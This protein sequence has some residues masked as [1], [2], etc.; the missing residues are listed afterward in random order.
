MSSRLFHLQPIGVGTPFV[1]SL[2]GYI[3]RLAEAHSVSLGT[4]IKKEIIQG[5]RAI[6]YIGVKPRNNINFLDS[7][8]A[9]EI[10]RILEEKT[11]NNNLKYLTMSAWKECFNSQYMFR[12]SLA[13]CPICYEENKRLKQ[14]I[15]EQLIWNFNGVHICKKHHSRLVQKCPFCDKES[16]IFSSR[17]QVGYC[18][19]CKSWLGSLKAEDIQTSSENDEYRNWIVDDIGQLLATGP[20]MGELN[21]QQFK[22]NIVNIKKIFK[23]SVYEIANE[24]DMPPYYTGNWMRGIRP[25]FPKALMLAHKY[26]YSL[27]D[28]FVKDINNIKELR[29]NGSRL[30]QI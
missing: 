15:Y 4:L 20:D 3:K 14:P 7:A 18:D 16:S 2:T 21:N 12:K 26:G 22:K 29:S 24:L 13:W 5:S 17:S 10:I 1:E 30:P 9:E 25:T 11:C 8:V 23:I 27:Y 19:N 28:I 6:N